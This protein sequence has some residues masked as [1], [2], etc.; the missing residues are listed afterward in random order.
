MN[1]LRNRMKRFS[2]RH[3]VLVRRL[4]VAGTAVAVLLSLGLI[5]RMI[6]YR[7]SDTGGPLVTS[8]REIPPP[9]PTETPAAALT[10]AFTDDEATA[11]LELA[12]REKLPLGDFRVT[13]GPPNQVRMEGSLEKRDL[14]VFVGEEGSNLLKAALLLAPETIDVTAAFSVAES[15]GTL[16]VTPEEVRVLGVSVL[17]FLPEETADI[18]RDTIGG[19]VP[20]GAR[21]DALHIGDGEAEIRLKVGL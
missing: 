3:P 15:E 11:L 20:E 16:A 8:P 6:F 13:F 19:I 17:S 18:L 14:A 9:S 5:L 7:E 2:E 4:Y 10:L 1:K 21:I 12:V